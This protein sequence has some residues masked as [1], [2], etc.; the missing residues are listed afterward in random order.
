MASLSAM[1][2]MAF[3]PDQLV[4]RG[5][6]PQRLHGLSSQILN[7]VRPADLAAVRELLPEENKAAK[8]LLF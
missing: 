2:L 8:R 1:A 6:G 7:R 3:Q 5:Q 4:S